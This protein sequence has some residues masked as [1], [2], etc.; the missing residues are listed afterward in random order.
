M[1]IYRYRY[2]Y[3]VHICIYIYIYVTDESGRIFIPVY[4]CR[5]P[6]SGALKKEIYTFLDILF[7]DIFITGYVP[8]F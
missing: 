3:I 2:R 8:S 6:N 1:Y 5:H 4:R 7:T